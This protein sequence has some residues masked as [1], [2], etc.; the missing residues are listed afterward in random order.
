ME[1]KYGNPDE[2]SCSWW[3]SFVHD[4]FVCTIKSKLYIVWGPPIDLLEIWESV[5][6]EKLD[7]WPIKT[8]VTI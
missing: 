4:S 7:L 6:P 2:I 8:W 3:H 1:M 5:K